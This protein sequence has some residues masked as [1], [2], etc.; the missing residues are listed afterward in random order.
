[1]AVLVWI[2]SPPYL[3]D[4]GDLRVREPIMLCVDFHYTD[5]LPGI[6]RDKAFISKSS[7]HKNQ[8]AKNFNFDFVFVKLQHYSLIKQLFSVCFYFQ[9]KDAP[10]YYSGLTIR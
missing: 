4:D 3:A 2:N 10:A 1:V 7:T 8:F 9:F 5:M 6:P